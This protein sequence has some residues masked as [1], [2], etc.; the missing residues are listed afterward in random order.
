[1]ANLISTQIDFD[2]LYSPTDEE[3]NLAKDLNKGKSLSD[4]RTR[5]AKMLK[6]LR[7][8]AW[9]TYKTWGVTKITT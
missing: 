4:G 6:K 2:V 3:Y 7:A 1:M 5:G 8:H 9:E